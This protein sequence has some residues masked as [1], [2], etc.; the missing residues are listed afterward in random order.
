ML[1]FTLTYF[2]QFHCNFSIYTFIFKNKL[3]CFNDYGS[4]SI[5]TLVHRNKKNPLKVNATLKVH[6]FNAI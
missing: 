2:I 6:S 5:I 4:F 1:K 3:N